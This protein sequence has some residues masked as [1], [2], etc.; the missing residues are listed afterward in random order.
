M[1]EAARSD[2]LAAEEFDFGLI[3]IWPAVGDFALRPDMQRLATMS[4]LRVGRW[5]AWSMELDF[6]SWKMESKI[7]SNVI[8]SPQWNRYSESIGVPMI[9]EEWEW[10]S[11]LAQQAAIIQAL[12][13]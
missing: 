2:K 12:K 7:P 9:G 6:V 5:A 11:R 10:M 3:D 1:F 8:E 4:R 13:L